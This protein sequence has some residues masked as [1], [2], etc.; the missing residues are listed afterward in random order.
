MFAHWFMRMFKI[1]KLTTFVFKCWILLKS[2]LGCVNG[3]LHTFHYPPPPTWTEPAQ[4]CCF[5]LSLGAPFSVFLP[6]TVR[7]QTIVHRNCHVHFKISYYV[8]FVSFY[9]TLLEMMSKMTNLTLVGMT[10]SS[11]CL[12][13]DM[14]FQRIHFW[15]SNYKINIQFDIFAENWRNCCFDLELRRRR[16]KRSWCNLHQASRISWAAALIHIARLINM[17]SAWIWHSLPYFEI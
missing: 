7:L 15:S 10:K 9:N 3:S 2:V 12:C 5:G 8:T 16:V 17:A 4:F 13:D 11:A 1:S 14:A 6:V